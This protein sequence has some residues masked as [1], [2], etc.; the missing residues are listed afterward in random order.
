MRI[1]RIAIKAQ[2]RPLGMVIVFD[3]FL[4]QPVAVFLIDWNDM[5]QKFPAKSSKETLNEWI[6]PRAVIGRANFLYTAH[7]QKSSNTV[8]IV[9]VVVT[10]YEPW[11]PIEWKSFLELQDYPFHAGKPGD[12]EVENLSPGM[13][14]DDE[15]IQY[16]ESQSGNRAIIDSPRFMEMI[17]DEC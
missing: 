8:A 5:I 9:S 7:F 14:E 15:D 17:P 1:R 3:K 16:L 2:V 4:D 12:V 6:L 13:I 10:K 11:L